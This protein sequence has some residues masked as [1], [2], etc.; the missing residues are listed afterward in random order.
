M[1]EKGAVLLA[2]I[3]RVFNAIGTSETIR[4][5]KAELSTAMPAL[6]PPKKINNVEGWMADQ[7][8]AYQFF[9]SYMVRGVATKAFDMAKDTMRARG[10]FAKVENMVPGTSATVF[11]NEIMQIICKKKNPVRRFDEKKAFILLQTKGKIKPELLNA[12]W[13]ECYTLNKPAEEFEPTLKI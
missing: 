13:E 8:A 1:S 4:I 9:V 2:N 7:F 12:L 5:G 3:R 10:L 6:T 11:D